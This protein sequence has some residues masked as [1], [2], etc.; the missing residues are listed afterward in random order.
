MKRSTLKRIKTKRRIMKRPKKLKFIP[1]R[2]ISTMKN[3]RE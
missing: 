2:K 3:K 1:L